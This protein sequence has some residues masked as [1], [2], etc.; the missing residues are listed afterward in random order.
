MYYPR[1]CPGQVLVPY[2]KE[3]STRLAGPVVI[4][5]PCVGN[6]FQ[7]LGNTREKHLLLYS[8]E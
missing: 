3:Q 8:I 1:L 2:T 7:G 6:K 5:I 4:L